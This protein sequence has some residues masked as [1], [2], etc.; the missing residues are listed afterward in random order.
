MLCKFM[1]FSIRNQY[2]R[3]TKIIFIN[4]NFHQINS[5]IKHYVVHY[6]HFRIRT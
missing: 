2:Y 5:I 4:L 1:Q 6:E 3:D